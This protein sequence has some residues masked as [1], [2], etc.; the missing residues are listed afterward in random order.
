MPHY[1]VQVAYSHEGSA[2]IV[3][4]PQNRTEAVRPAVEKLGGKVT[5]GWYSLGKYDA[6][7]IV[8]MPS[9]LTAM[10]LAMA[11]SAGGAVKGVNTTP[12][13]TPEESVEAMKKTPTAAYKPPKRKP[14]PLN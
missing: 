14:V 5:S 7:L 12:L 9:N 1:L 3:E 2:A 11:F 10:A 4:K 8:E 6:V 13:L